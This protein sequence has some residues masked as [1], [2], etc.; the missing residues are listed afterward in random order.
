[1]KC[2]YSCFTLDLAWMRKIYKT[3]IIIVYVVMHTQKQMVRYIRK[4]EWAICWAFALHTNAHLKIIT[5]VHREVCVLLFDAFLDFD[6][7]WKVKMKSLTIA[8]SNLIVCPCLHMHTHTRLN[9]TITM[10]IVCNVV[11]TKYTYTH[12]GWRLL[13]S[14]LKILQ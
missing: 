12:I 4:S 6:G 14:K 8:L 5:A 9:C 11:Q 3:I 2:N 7:S 13:K 10:A 1:M